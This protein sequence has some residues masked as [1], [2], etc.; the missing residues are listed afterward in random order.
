MKLFNAD[1]S[2]NAFRTRLVINELGLD[3]PYV[4][5]DLRSKE[6]PAEFLAASPNGKV[7]AFVDD[8]GFTLFESRVINN[9]L[10]AKKP[11]RDLYPVDPKRRA[12]V[13]EWNS[14]QAVH[15]GPSMQAV[16]F[17]RVSK[18]QLGM[19]EAN[20]ETAKAKQKETE[21]Y[22][23]VLEKSLAGKEWIVDKLTTADFSLASTFPLAAK[24]GISLDAYPNI[25][26]W[27]ARIQALPSWNKSLPKY[28]RELLAS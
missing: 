14:W 22:L 28:V 10:A 8:D 18:K 3:V 9:W 12:R 21:G 11:D 20:E 24:A 19:G 1:G 26:K 17:E 27:Y 13:D 4:D 5:I 15:L 23:A 25:A 7:P 6:K 2:P 16:T